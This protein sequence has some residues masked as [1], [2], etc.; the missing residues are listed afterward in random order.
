MDMLLWSF[1]AVKSNTKTNF[2]KKLN[3]FLMFGSIFLLGLSAKAQLTQTVEFPIMGGNDDVEQGLFTGEMYRTSS[4]IEVTK[5]GSDEQLI[6]LRFAGIDIPSF[7]T[8]NSA[9][10][11]VVVDESN[12]TGDVNA[13]IVLE[14]TG[15]AASYGSGAFNLLNRDY[16]YGDTVIWNFGPFAQ[17]NDAGED[18]Q[19]P[20]LAVLITQAIGQENWNAGNAIAFA[21]VDPLYIEVP[22]YTGNGNNKRVFKTYD[23]DPS[24]AAKLVIEFTLPEMYFPGSFPVAAGSSWLYND[25][26]VDLSGESWT[27]IDYPAGDDWDY[28]DAKIGY[29]EADIVTELGFG[30]DAENKY[31][32]YYLRHIF[33]AENTASIDSLVFDV[34]RDDGA[35]VYV[36]GVEAFRMNMPEGEV[37][38]NTF[39]SE[40]VGDSDESAYFTVNTANLLQD[41]TN[42]IAVELHQ[43]SAS[44][45][46]LGFNMAVNFLE[47]PYTVAQYPL[48]AGSGW[49]YLDNGSDLG[50]E[51]WTSLAFD[52]Y[53]WNQGN[54]PLGYGDDVE[55][56][57]SFGP[58]ADNK[59]ITTYFRRTMNVDMT[60][61]ADSIVVG[62]RRDDGAIIYINGVEVVRDNMPEGDIDYLTFSA[63]IVSGD[64]EDTYFY[65][66]LSSNV[67]VD[68]DN[69][70]AVELHNRDGQS[71][72][73]GFD[74]YIQNLP[75]T[76]PPVDCSTD[77]IGCFTSIN[78]TGQTPNLIL[79]E[80]HRFQMILK[81]GTPH[82]I[83]E[84]NI[85][86]NH[87]FTGY[88][89]LD[90]SSTVGHL[91]VNHETSP[92]GVTIADLHYNEETLLWEIDSTQAVDFY[93]EDLVS[94]IRNCSGGLTP[95]GTII[96][97]EE[98]TSGGDSN[99]DGYQDIGW[100]VEI[101]PI[102]AKV[103]DYENDGV[104]DKLWAMG[105]MNH[106]NVV[107][108]DDM[109]RAFYGEDGGTQLVYKF[110]ADEPGN[111]S[112][113][114]VYVL[115]LNQELVGGDPSGTTGLW[116]QVPNDTPEER[117]NIRNAGAALGGTN[118]NGVEDCEISPIDGK[119]YFT[120]KG[121][122]RTYRF[123][124]GDNGV[125]AFE[126]FVGGRS[127]DIETADGIVS[128]NWGGGNDN[129][130]FDNQ[131]N[132][133]VQ[134]D[135]GLNYIWVVRPDHSQ[136]TPHVELFASVPNGSEPTGLTFS[137]DN[138][139]G[140][141]S[142]QHPSGSNT[143]Q[144]DATGNEV[145]FDK[146]ATVIFSLSNFL[147]AENLCLAYG[148][149]IAFGDG[150]DQ[151][152]VLV[153][154]DVESNVTVQFD[155]LPTD[156]VAGIWVV[157]DTE[158]NI[159]GLPSTIADV[160]AVNFDD[161]G[162][163]SCLIWFLS[164]D[165][166]SS[167]V[168]ELAAAF[169][170]GETVN[171]NELTGCYDLSE[172]ITVIR[173]S[174]SVIDCEDYAI[175]LADVDQDS[176]STIYEVT[177]DAVATS[178]SLEA[179]QTVDYEVHIAF[180]ESDKLLYLVR[181]E[182]GSYRTLNV[183]SGNAEL[184]EEVALSTPLT[185]VTAAVFAEDGSL[186]IGDMDS[187]I[188]AAVDVA[189][190]EQS[191]YATAN[192]SG[193]DISFGLDGT[194]YMVSRSFGG[195]MYAINTNGGSHTVLGSVSHKVMGMATMS[196]GNLLVASRDAGSLVAYGVDGNA[197][198]LEFNLSLDGAPFNTYNGD[199]G[200][201]CT[202]L[203]ERFT[204]VDA[205]TTYTEESENEEEV[206]RVVA[207]DDEL[208]A[209]P[210]PTEGELQIVFKT[211]ETV[212]TT[213]QVVDMNGRV[214][215][216]LFNTMS[217]KDVENRVDF[218]GLD[219][220]NGVYIYRMVTENQTI[221]NKFVIAR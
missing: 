68:G 7:A 74:M 71:S 168:A 24:V 75:A 185:K 55:T 134:Q 158:G 65:H 83:G 149:E 3:S 16:Y 159:L 128:E 139:F 127:Y 14:N 211:A 144:I 59:Y 62:L 31:P 142:V 156:D 220:P 37:T 154:D 121:N 48:P 205:E 8:I 78:P 173:E 76:N 18:Q 30:D 40:T 25:N 174:A 73:L 217:E 117:N 51:D 97:A 179:I 135:G 89:G 143:P 133:W 17:V 140:F 84:G 130:T 41:G 164:Y 57:V 126:T 44:S 183:M 1:A 132:L 88:I 196:N 160:E 212:F 162:T 9:Y 216:T 64:D 145:I 26:G 198:G 213:V 111:L 215:E 70:I 147:G 77:H 82:T 95:W 85:G 67:F 28:G 192:V 61:I 63:S 218:N 137:P 86:G 136:I 54:G 33:E 177:L 39:A 148:G 93:N 181:S 129:L 191:P 42:V 221:V 118:F 202:D 170:N 210:N 141:F 107:V 187:G 197:T 92:G 108:A 119:I 32:T 5:D 109:I 45:S 56:V 175:Y 91:S 103:M 188:I 13:A 66:I 209:F 165:A 200:A 152:V 193:G 176:V 94:T 203:Q 72:D 102:T 53:L 81:Q 214:V 105:R 206:I 22:G 6:G 166:D 169:A 10:I 172:S 87:D 189:T 138:K 46:D 99:G 186:L 116:V 114:D 207:N 155:I 120:S 195:K 35:I 201:G 125:T 163:G 34:L 11:Q 194:P 80:G 115:S 153:N 122:G 112:S 50:S 131:G 219:L 208:S 124:D 12:T 151:A 19:S 167:N 161:A 21:L 182:G 69:Q 23:N 58:D 79:P 20:D 96:T 146:S 60:D 106:E 204:A 101:D 199:M 49:N 98:N 47:V 2:M 38:Y 110:V 178:A 100:L 36:N 184:S 157:T 171:A 150:D 15:D 190:G 52:D 123:T 27:A 90:G 180:N 113:G 4:D 29:G 104:Q 43:A